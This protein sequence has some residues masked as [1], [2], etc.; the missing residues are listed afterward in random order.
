[1]TLPTVRVVLEAAAFPLDPLNVRVA[2]GP[3]SPG[4]SPLPASVLGPQDLERDRSASLARTLERL[5]GVGTLS[6]GRES[7]SKRFA[8]NP[9]RDVVLRLRMDL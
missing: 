7:R 5:P 4:S 3:L 8:L 9:G 2:R 1:M 6:T